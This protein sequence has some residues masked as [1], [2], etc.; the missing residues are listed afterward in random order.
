MRVLPLLCLFPAF[1]A[2]AHDPIGSTSNSLI[3]VRGKTVDYYLNMSPAISKLLE[4]EVDESS[5]DF[6]DY[7]ASELKVTSWDS[8]CRLERIDRAPPEST[9]N[10]IVHLV[11][12][13][14]REVRDLSVES[15]LF[16]DLDETHTQLARLAPPEDPR[17]SLREG[18]LTASNRTFHIPDVRT[19]GS[20]SGD[21]LLAFF[22]LG[23][24]HLLTGYDH[25][26]FLLAAIIAMS[27][28]DTFKAVTA[29]TLAHS[30]TMALAF[31]G[32][33]S[34]PSRIVE[35][36]IALT[37]V[38]VA[39]ENVLTPHARRRWALTGLFGL[40]HG[41]GFVGAL[42]TIAISRDELLLSLVSFNSG[43]EVGQ[44][45]VI[46]AAAPA[47]WY[48]GTR[49]WHRRF[50]RGFSMGVGAL[51]TFWLVQRVLA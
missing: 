3:I 22:K 38:Y 45:V 5:A 42:K 8:E 7:F 9:G 13:C 33:V 36:L 46:A 47:L 1:L 31:L 48:L 12:G 15:T 41:L 2:T 29:F 50:C 40:V 18:V 20:A 26:L 6:Q 25:I 34:L 49:S 32:V 39:I 30:L 14:P 11:F 23:I 10:R 21:R 37:I 27:L 16:L 28:L 35:P 51:G 44:L 19:G 24:E 4:G 17:R 43:I